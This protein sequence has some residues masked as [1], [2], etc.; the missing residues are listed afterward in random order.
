[1]VYTKQ[2]PDGITQKLNLVYKLENSTVSTKEVDHEK[3]MT[4]PPLTSYKKKVA[5]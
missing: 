1:M 4:I 3:S 5:S 2:Y